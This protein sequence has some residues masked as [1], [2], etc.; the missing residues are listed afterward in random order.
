MAM[1]VRH[2]APQRLDE[3]CPLLAGGALREVGEPLGVVLAGDDCREHRPAAQA[4]HVGQ[5]AGDLDVRGLQHL[6]DA[7]RVQ[8]WEISRTSCL[9]VRVRSR[10]S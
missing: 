9:R 8:C 10:S 2:V 3:L 4:Q 5:D 1:V 6:L 7:Q